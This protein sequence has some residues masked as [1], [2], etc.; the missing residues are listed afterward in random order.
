MKLRFRQTS[1]NIGRVLVKRA[2]NNY[3]VTGE[4]YETT[5][6][7]ENGITYREVDLTEVIINEEG[8]LYFVL[9][10]PGGQELSIYS[11][12]ATTDYKPKIIERHSVKRVN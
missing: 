11:N 8:T 12:N 1:E 9:E 6:V 5:V 4:E 10:S 3:L 7:L 2:T